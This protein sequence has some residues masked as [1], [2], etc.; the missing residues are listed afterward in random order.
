MPPLVANY[1]L[2]ADL[3]LIYLIYSLFYYKIVKICYILNESDSDM[4]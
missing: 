3:I 1:C 4:S 2:P